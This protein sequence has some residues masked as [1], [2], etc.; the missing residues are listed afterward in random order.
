[1]AQA[2]AIEEMALTITEDEEL[3]LSETEDCLDTDGE[4]PTK[5]GTGEVVDKNLVAPD[6]R[7]R[8]SRI[9]EQDQEAGKCTH[10]SCTYTS[11]IPASFFKHVESHNI[12][13][14]CACGYFSSIRDS[15]RAAWQKG[16]HK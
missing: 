7:S 3:T 4:A 12:L 14:I 6:T 5:T 11:V 15:T 13:Y 8:I 1:M 9:Y 16:P 10:K 2:Q